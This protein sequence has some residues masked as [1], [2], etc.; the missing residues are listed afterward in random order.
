MSYKF[1]AGE[2]LTRGG[3]KAVVL[4][5]SFHGETYPLV[6]FIEYTGGQYIRGSWTSK[7]VYNACTDSEAHRDLMPPKIWSLGSLSHEDEF[8]ASLQANLDVHEK[9]IASL[10]VEVEM[11]DKEIRKWKEAWQQADDEAYKYADEL[12]SL[13]EFCRMEIRK[14][15]PDYVAK[16]EAEVTTLRTTNDLLTSA[17]VRLRDCDWIITPLVSAELAVREIA[18]EALKEQKP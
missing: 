2:Y 11:K 13:Q 4:T 12:K 15:P 6:G 18:R 7:G 16:L 9:R 17:L 3:K 1:E 10:V 8:V 14:M 5:D